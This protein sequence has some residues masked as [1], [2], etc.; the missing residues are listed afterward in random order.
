MRLRTRAEPLANL[1]S[2]G[3]GQGSEGLWSLLIAR[4]TRRLPGLCCKS[5]RLGFCR[6]NDGRKECRPDGVLA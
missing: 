4:M 3:S 1:L 2:I 5:C 6:F